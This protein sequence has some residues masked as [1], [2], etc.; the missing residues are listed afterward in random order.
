M[1]DDT[2]ASLRSCSSETKGNPSDLIAFAG[3]E[4]TQMG[5]SPKTHYGHKN[6]ILRSLNEVPDKPIGAGNTGIDL[7]IESPFTPAALLIADFPPESI[8]L[9]FLKYR[10]TIYS[11][12]ICSQNRQNPSS[13]CREDAPTPEILFN[14]LDQL[15]LD[16][17]VIPHGTTWGIHAPPESAFSMQLNDG[18]H[19]PDRQRLIEV[20]SGH[21]NSE[22]YRKIQH[23]KKDAEG[24]NSL[25]LI[26]I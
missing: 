19:D 3:W 15:S 8:D 11:T 12:P 14:K 2:I 6:I 23:V 5:N 18:N 24:N 17:L 20:Y 7:I 9:D 16:S 1:W 22:R 10:R 25:S 13:E 4:W 21:G 26:H